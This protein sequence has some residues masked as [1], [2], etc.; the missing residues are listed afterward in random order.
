MTKRATHLLLSSRRHLNH[1][2]T[3]THSTIRMLTLDRMETRIPGASDAPWCTTP[4]ILGKS[5]SCGTAVSGKM[6]SGYCDAQSRRECR[7][8]GGRQRRVRRIFGLCLRICTVRGGAA[9]APAALAVLA[10]LRPD[11]PLARIAF[12][13][14]RRTASTT[15]LVIPSGG[16]DRAKGR[17]RCERQE[18]IILVCSMRCRT[19]IVHDDGA[20][21]NVDDLFAAVRKELRELLVGLP[22]RVW[23]VE[24]EE[25]TDVD[26]VAPVRRRRDLS[27]TWQQR[28]VYEHRRRGGPSMRTC[29]HRPGCG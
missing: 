23:V 26:P 6:K 9:A 2:T 14:A 16:E 25:A 8:Q 20:K 3:D 19:G 21:A 12:T 1:G 24:E 22:V 29:R 10:A 18:R 17:R 15:A 13:P 28:A 7:M 5:Q 4:S 11:Q 27:R